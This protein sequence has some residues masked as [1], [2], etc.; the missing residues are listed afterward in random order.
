[1]NYYYT[2]QNK[3]NFQIKFSGFDASICFT[4]RL[5]HLMLREKMKAPKATCD[6]LEASRQLF[7]TLQLEKD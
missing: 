1:M 2:M 3:T 7:L 5:A 4:P 6:S